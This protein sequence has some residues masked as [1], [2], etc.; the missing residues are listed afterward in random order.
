MM[1]LPY[2]PIKG[3]NRDFII[4][5]ISCSCQTKREWPMREDVY[6]AFFNRKNRKLLTQFIDMNHFLMPYEGPINETAR[7]EEQRIQL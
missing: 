2:E 5:C 7:N 6:Q 3:K 1:Q 4:F